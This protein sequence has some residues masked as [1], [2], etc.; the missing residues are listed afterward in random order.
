MRDR[1]LIALACF[2]AVA[3]LAACG[4]GGGGSSTPTIGGIGTTPTTA[5]TVAAVPTP[6]LAA[7]QAL[8][9]FTITLP[10]TTTSST[11]R[12]A[13]Y[14]DPSTASLTL[15]LLT[16][17]GVATNSTPQGPFNT[18]AG[19]PGCVTTSGT[20][21]CTFAIAAPI[22][23]DVFLANT[24]SALNAVGPLG[25]GAVSF[26]VAANST[27]SANLTLTGPIA[28]ITLVSNNG[29][30]SDT[31]W[32]GNGDFEPFTYAEYQA[33]YNSDG[34][35]RAHAQT[36]A[37]PTP[38][39]TAIPSERAFLI[40]EDAQGNTI[41]SPTTYNQPVTLT[42]HLNG[43]TANALLSVTPPAG[44]GC[45][46]ASTSTDGGTVLACTPFDLVT[47][48][49]IPGIN[50]YYQVYDYNSYNYDYFNFPYVTASLSSAPSTV[51]ANLPFTIE[52]NPVPS[53]TPS[54]VATA[55]GS[56]TVI[57]Q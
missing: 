17:N 38:A 32:N 41:F 57:G 23:T 42:L 25:Q 9:H 7:G 24:Y 29:A 54:P 22:G 43:G 55:S 15:T 51:L 46:A 50:S 26:S 34:K 1:K 2:A 53:S 56:L 3:V 27:N 47:L 30:N 44:F 21:T 13:Q 40:A 8:A 49:L 39:P 19:Q 18:Q 14:V 35:A 52:A 31:L 11:K 45:S 37:T 12:R 33:Y 6:T 28:S 48:S 5:P 16:N 20:T 36:I 4:G 10:S